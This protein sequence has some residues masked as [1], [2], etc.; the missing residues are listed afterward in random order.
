MKKDKLRK[1][2]DEEKQKVLFVVNDLIPEDMP[3]EPTEYDVLMEQKR[4]EFISHLLRDNEDSGIEAIVK[5][6]EKYINRDNSFGFRFSLI[7]M[8]DMWI[9]DSP[10][11]PVMHNPEWEEWSKLS[12]KKV[13]TDEI[14]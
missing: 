6:C 1:L 11:W 4:Q 9:N 3:E 8:Y 14:K 10:V 5:G 13:K 7:M 2:T 12:E